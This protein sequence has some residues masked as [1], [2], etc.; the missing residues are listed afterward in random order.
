ML[1]KSEVA[2]IIRPVS[3]ECASV[4]EI[5]SNTG[6]KCVNAKSKNSQ[7]FFKIKKK[8]GKITENGDFWAKNVEKSILLF[9]CS[10][11]TNNRT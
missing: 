7:Y 6:F 11:K 2:M 1:D 5:D 10:S 4:S 8:L 3:A 9:C